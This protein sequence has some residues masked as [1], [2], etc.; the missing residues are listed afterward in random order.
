M[1]ISHNFDGGN[2]R[3]ISI[4]DASDI[5][6]EINKDNNADFSQW[7]YFRLTGA[8]NQDC[9]LKLVNAGTTSYVKGWEG[10]QAVA[11][12]DRETWFRVDTDF[13]GEVLTI[14]HTPE[15]DSVYYAYFAPY[16][17]ERHHDLIASA[18]LSELVQYEHLGYTLDGQDMDLLKVGIEGEG[19]KVCWLI[20]RQHPGETMAQ[21]WMEGMLNAL[22]DPEDPISRELLNHAVF[23]IVPNMNPDGSRRGNLRTNAAG[24]NLNREWQTPSMAQSPEVFLVR[25][26]MEQTG[27]SFCLDVHGDEALPYNF[28]AG[29]EGINDWN[30][31]RQELLDFYQ[32]ALVTASPDFQT[33]VGYDKDKHG[34]ALMTVGTN[35]IA[36]TF[37][38][39]A[40]TLE[41]PFKDT[42][43]TPDDYLGWSPERSRKLG[44]AS[45][46][47][48]YQTLAK[49]K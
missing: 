3:C 42:I 46:H 10:Y 21:W 45:L 18:Q 35:Y 7:F 9:Q 22:L 47:A 15:C 40:M 36:Q 33:K 23:Y 16:S 14:N 6:L 11:S 48:L 32:Q 43:D 34:E 13:D 5:Q 41:M 19:K 8:Q 17:M 49:L 2:I 4:N 39:L 44:V 27:M 26:K 38:C 28:I 12:Y 30:D 20:A 31:Q 1:K 25:Q 29:S 24:A 37:D